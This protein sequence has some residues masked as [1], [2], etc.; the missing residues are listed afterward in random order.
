MEKGNLAV[1]FVAGD[2]ARDPRTLSEV[3]TEDGLQRICDLVGRKLAGRTEHCRRKTG[4]RDRESA[5][6]EGK[7]S[8]SMHADRFWGM[9][10]RS[11]A[12]IGRE[13]RRGCVIHVELAAPHIF[14]RLV[15]G[16]AGAFHR[17]PRASFNFAG[18]RVT[19]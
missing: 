16:A 1:K 7:E 5:E 8:G 18:P 15:L 6:K 3:D 14:G 9:C 12:Q 19:L 17:G 10:E 4:G 2:G 13:R 11:A